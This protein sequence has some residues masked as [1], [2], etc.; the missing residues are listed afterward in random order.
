MWIR[1]TKMMRATA[2]EMTAGN[3]RTVLVKSK[4]VQALCISHHSTNKY[5]SLHSDGTHVCSD[6]NRSKFMK[7]LRHPRTLL[8]KLR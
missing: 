2:E 7:E 6:D 8:N 4:I 5:L 3:W 1:V